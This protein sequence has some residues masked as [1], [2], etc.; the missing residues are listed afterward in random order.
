M[1]NRILIIENDPNFLFL[2]EKILEFCK[3]K[4]ISATSGREGLKLAQE[5][6]P[7][8]IIVDV[9]FLEQNETELVHT[10]KSNDKTSKIPVIALTQ[11][12]C[13]QNEDF[14]SKA[15][16]SACISMPVDIPLFNEAVQRALS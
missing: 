8:G 4:V 3:F 1:Q 14:L 7:D 9:C 13:R 6:P 2:F 10:L 15:G 12:L 11:S 5:N 16:F